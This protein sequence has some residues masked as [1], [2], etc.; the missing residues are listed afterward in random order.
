MEKLFSIWKFFWPHC[1]SL[2]ASYVCGLWK[3]CCHAPFFRWKTPTCMTVKRAFHKL[4]HHLLGWWVKIY[5]K[6]WWRVKKP[7]YFNKQHFSSIFY[8]HFYLIELIRPILCL[9]YM[10]L[11]CQVLHGHFGPVYLLQVPFSCE[12]WWALLIK[13]INFLSKSHST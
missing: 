12:F 11:A 7:N 13:K 1:V 3:I 9:K 4:R 5:G 8:H 10:E 6:K 2:W